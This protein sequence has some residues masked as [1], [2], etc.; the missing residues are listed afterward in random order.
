MVV[1]AWNGSFLGFALRN[2]VAMG[3]VHTGYNPAL[4][5]LP[6]DGGLVVGLVKMQVS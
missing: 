2:L 1:K 5:C 4:I 3:S 6:V